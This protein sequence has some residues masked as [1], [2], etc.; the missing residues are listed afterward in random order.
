M[1][2][3]VGLD[4]MKNGKQCGRKQGEVN[5]TKSY[6]T[7]DKKFPLNSQRVLRPV[8]IGGLMFYMMVPAS[9]CGAWSCALK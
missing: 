4:N 6:V 1:A 5:N 7:D 3:N 9:V 8:K 2:L